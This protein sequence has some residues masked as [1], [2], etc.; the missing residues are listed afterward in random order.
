[1]ESMQQVD[2]SEL[3]LRDEALSQG[4]IGVWA[5]V[6]SLFFAMMGPFTCYTG[7]FLALPIA[8]LGLYTSWRGHEAAQGIESARAERQLATAGLVAN[9]VTTLFVG[10]ILLFVFAILVMYFGLIVIAAIAGALGA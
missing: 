10:G 1:M 9:G 2:G 4:T 8:L 3:V 6:G 5:G 7:Y